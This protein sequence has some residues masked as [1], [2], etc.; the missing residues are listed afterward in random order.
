MPL[1]DKLS[2]P[3]RIFFLRNREVNNSGERVLALLKLVNLQGQIQDFWKGCLQ[4]IMMLGCLCIRFADFI[5]FNFFL[6]IP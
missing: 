6:N 4:C 2:T 1:E 3:T 5:A